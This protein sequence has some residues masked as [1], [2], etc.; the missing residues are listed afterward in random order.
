VDNSCWDDFTT[1][2][3]SGDWDPRAD[4]NNGTDMGEQDGVINIPD[5][6]TIVEDYEANAQVTPGTI[7]YLETL[8]GDEPGA[9]DGFILSRIGLDIAYEPINEDVSI[10]LELHNVKLSHGD[11]TP[12]LPYNDNDGIYE[13]IMD[14]DDNDG[15]SNEADNCRYE[16]NSGQED[17]DGSCEY[18]PM[19]YET[20]P[21]CGDACEAV[22]MI[23]VDPEENIFHSDSS[24]VGDNFELN[25]N[26]T[27]ARYLY[28]FEFKLS[29]DPNLLNNSWATYGDF[30]DAA[31]AG[32]S[33]NIVVID[34]PGDEPNGFGDVNE[35]GEVDVYDV[36]IISRAFGSNCNN[37]TCSV[38]NSC[39]SD[40]TTCT[41]TGDWDPR[42]DIFNGTDMGE[43]DGVIDIGDIVTIV[44]D[45][46][47]NAQVT[48]GTIQY[49][50]VLIGD[51]AGAF[52]NF[53]L[54]MIGFK[55]A[56]EPVN[57]N[58]S[59][60]LRLYD[61]KLGH[62][63][64]KSIPHN[65]INGTYEFI[66][67]DADKDGWSNEADN[68]IAVPNPDQDNSDHDDLGNACDNCWFISNPDQLDSDG[69]CP[70]MPF[71]EEPM[72][73]DECRP[74]GGKFGV[75]FDVPYW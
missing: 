40:F 16:P 32:N 73:G 41:V 72:C 60:I 4:I 54:S 27:D 45:Y 47:A 24:N 13:F 11:E 75:Y 20:D 5:I 21:K 67:D 33:F 31:G 43:Q 18:I 69:D 68:C 49:L 46:E 10:I 71:L 37:A 39:W 66:I 62:D 26:I 55:I 52:D 64:E 74:K 2:T 8:V 23:Y 19:P 6:V 3:I 48:P 28:G 12:I 7:Q 34:Q 35:D 22:P 25:V 14:D 65:T 44:K 17:T 59:C 30:K 63:N 9:N 1:C 70:A 57:E 61:T 15:W 42:A 36:M 51:E 56:Y 58:V 38:D 50:E 29:Y 53:T